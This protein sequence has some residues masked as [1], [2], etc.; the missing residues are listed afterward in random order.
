M[1]IGSRD[2]FKPDNYNRKNISALMQTR[3]KVQKITKKIPHAFT[4][5]KVHFS[6]LQT[7]RV[8]EKTN[9]LFTQ[10]MKTFHS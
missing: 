3:D 10:K 1:K 5:G 9:R 2:S 7:N 4:A 8:S 6:K